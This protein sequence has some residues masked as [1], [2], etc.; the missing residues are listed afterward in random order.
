MQIDV[1]LRSDIR[2][3]RR[4][5]KLNTNAMNIALEHNQIGRDLNKAIEDARA[6]MI[7]IA[8]EVNHA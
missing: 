8:G 5:S 2:D 7:E 3:S 4:V 6:T 1:K